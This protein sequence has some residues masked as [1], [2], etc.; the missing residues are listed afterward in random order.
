VERNP[1]GH[2]CG[3]SKNKKNVALIIVSMVCDRQ[4]LGLATAIVFAQKNLFEV[5]DDKIL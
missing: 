5:L 1:P 3:P 2:F 4:L